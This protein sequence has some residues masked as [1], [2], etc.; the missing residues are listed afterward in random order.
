M[1]HFDDITLQDTYE[2]SIA[3]VRRLSEVDH[4]EFEKEFRAV[5]QL[6]EAISPSALLVPYRDQYRWLI[7]I[8][9]VYL[10][11]YKRLDFDAEFYAAK[12]RQLINEST[13]ILGFKGHLP[14]VKIDS[15]YLDVL[16]GSKLSPDDKAEKI[17]RDIETVIRQSEVANPIYVDF[18]K[19]LEEI[20][21]QKRN[22]S[23]RIEDTLLEL[24]QLF[25]EVEETESLPQKM[26]FTDMGEFYFFQE[27]KNKF[28]DT[29]PED[30]TKA[31]AMKLGNLIRDKR[32]IGWADSER[33]KKSIKSH[34]E[35]WLC[36]EEFEALNLCDDD[37]LAELFLG[38]MVNQYK[39]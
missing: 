37:E 38:H 39:L 1:S 31:L 32:Y 19:R 24:E 3:I 33:E 22:K 28:G 36:S 16:N 34:I 17:I 21:K 35:F 29:L 15:T 10:S 2:C 12:T 7:A 30:A 9:Q 18:L 5:Y 13:Q 14:S 4:T 8:Y 20:I 26:G 6:Y 11:E 25:T 23:K 27:M